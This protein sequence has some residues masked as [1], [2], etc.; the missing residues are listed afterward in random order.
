MEIP[1]MRILHQPFARKPAINPIIPAIAKLGVTK[2]LPF[3]KK[4]PDVKYPQRIQ[5]SVNSTN[6]L[7]S[8]AADRM[9]MSRALM[10]ANVELSCDTGRFAA[11]FCFHLDW[12]ANR[13]LQVVNANP[14]RADAPGAYHFLGGRKSANR[15]SPEGC[16]KVAGG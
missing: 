11:Y 5:T 2:A 16:Q 3:P 8:E 10:T 13:A 9:L 15:S 12:Q 7:R 14:T 6:A 4:S 1:K